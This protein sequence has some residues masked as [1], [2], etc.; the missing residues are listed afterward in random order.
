MTSMPAVVTAAEMREL[1]RLT[2]EEVGVPGAVLMEHAGRAVADEVAR[3]TGAG[4]RVAVVCGAGNN[5]GDGHVCARWLREHGRDARVILVMGRPR[6]GGDAALHLAAYEKLGGPVV[7]ARDAAG[8]AALDAEL[9]V[10]AVV[11]DALFGTGLVRD[12]DGHRSEE[13]R[14]GKECRL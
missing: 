3:L 13:R 2:I 11:V 10:A 4:A 12:V 5:G 8:L 9:A 7:E 1:D 6:A 14:V